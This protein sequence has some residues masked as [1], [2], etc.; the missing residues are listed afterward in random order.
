M[1]D[2]LSA[3]FCLPCHPTHSC[4]QATRGGGV[5]KG[6]AAPKYMGGGGGGA[7]QGS[8]RNVKVTIGNKLRWVPL[9]TS[10]CHEVSLAMSFCPES[11]LLPTVAGVPAR[12][13]SHRST[14][15]PP[16]L[17]PPAAAAQRATSQPAAC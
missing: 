4:Q 8:N 14:M 17:P 2:A 5:H 16:P 10:F 11:L 3:Y 15:L 1:P 13:A 6:G 7:R 12:Q 9:A